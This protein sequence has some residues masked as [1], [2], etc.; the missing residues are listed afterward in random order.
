MD[1]GR[2]GV[3]AGS[4][5]PFSN[6]HLE[7]VRKALLLCDKLIIAVACSA[8]KKALFSSAE[9]VD[10]IISALKHAMPAE[11]DRLEI[12]YFEGLVV[13]LAKQKGATIFIRGVRDSID[14][15][16]EMQVLQVNHALNS[17]VLTVLIPVLN[18]LGAIRSSIIKQV[19]SMGG[20]VDKWVP[21]LVAAA[22]KKKY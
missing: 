8:N 15:N 1:S 3:F 21:P 4:F 22:L 10:F 20:N 14:Y 5:D 6:G 7:V 12:L 19:A 9:R 16:Y 2:I 13:D 17:G 18:E 11:F